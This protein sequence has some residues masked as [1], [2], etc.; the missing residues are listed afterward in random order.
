MG[1]RSMTVMVCA[2]LVG[3]RADGAVRCEPFEA[4]ASPPNHQLM[5]GD[6]PVDEALC[7]AKVVGRVDQPLDRGPV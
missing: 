4:I 1:E 5:R 7:A 2:G 3:G 6:N